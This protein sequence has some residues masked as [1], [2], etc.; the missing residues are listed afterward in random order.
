M[1]DVKKYPEL[2]YLGILPTPILIVRNIMRRNKWGGKI[3]TILF[4]Q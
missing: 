1:Y 3:V 2:I 4:M